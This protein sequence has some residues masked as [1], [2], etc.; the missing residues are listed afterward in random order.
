MTG[1]HNGHASVRGNAGLDETLLQ[2]LADEDYTLAE[3]LKERGY[4]TACIGK[5]G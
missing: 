3:M 5:W 4:N 2:S 1:R